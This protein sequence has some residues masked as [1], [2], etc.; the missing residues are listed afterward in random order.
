MKKLKWFTLVEILIVIVIIG[1]LI[2]ALVP[3]MQS[4]QWRARDVARKNDLAQLQAAIVTSQQDK[5]E[6]P[7]LDSGEAWVWLNDADLSSLLIRAGLNAVPKDPL[8]SNTVSWL[9]TTAYQPG[10][11]AYMLATKNWTRQWWFVLMAKTETEWWSNYVI[12]SGGG[13]TSTQDIAKDIFVCTRVDEA[14]GDQT[15]HW[16]SESDSTCVYEEVDQLR[17]I[18][19]Y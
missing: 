10:E 18:L 14:V 15:C 11:Y 12:C 2:W 19:T 13:I 17:Y 9:W 6:W 16:A 4:A 8:T 5:W 3:R 7:M 1:I